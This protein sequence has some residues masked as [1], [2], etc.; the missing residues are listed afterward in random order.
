MSPRFAKEMSECSQILPDKDFTKSIGV[1][2]AIVSS[3]LACRT[4]FACELKRPPFL[5]LTRAHEALV[6]FKGRSSIPSEG[7]KGLGFK[8]E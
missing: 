1:Y 4:E 7:L 8:V 6:I 5:L 2:F 3:E